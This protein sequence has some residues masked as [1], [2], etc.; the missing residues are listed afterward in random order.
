MGKV[1]LF[2]FEVWAR[3]QPYLRCTLCHLH[4]FLN[5]DRTV[6]WHRRACPHVW[7]SGNRGSS[8]FTVLGINSVAKATTRKST[9][10]PVGH[11]RG[12]RNRALTKGSMLRALGKAI[13]EVLTE[14]HLVYHM[15]NL[16]RH[17]TR[18]TAAPHRPKN[19]GTEGSEDSPAS[20]RQGGGQA[21]DSTRQL[22]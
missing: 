15:R 3:M 5:H 7:Q 12:Q 2:R 14:P 19:R 21:P 11:N 9:E 18:G 6:A 8:Q 20:H 16:R 22:G 4:R 10:V 13:Q 1:A 17:Y